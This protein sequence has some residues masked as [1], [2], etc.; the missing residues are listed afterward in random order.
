MQLSNDQ[1]GEN[2]PSGNEKETSEDDPM[3]QFLDPSFKDY[4]GEK[5]EVVDSSVLEDPTVL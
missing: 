4:I 5:Y 3:N 2:L 1:Q